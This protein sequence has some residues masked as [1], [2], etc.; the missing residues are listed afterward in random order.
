MVVPER[1][2]R[3][4]LEAVIGVGSF[5]TVHRA[6]DDW[7]E[8]TVA[9]KV[10]AENHSLNPE[11]RERFIAEGRSLRRIT[12]PHVVTV[13]DIG[14]SQHQQPYLVLELADRGTLADRVAQ[15]RR[16]GWTATPADV[17]VLARE[18]AAAV[19]AVHEAHLV[20]R[21]LSPGNLLLT[22]APGAGLVGTGASDPAD[23][24]QP[25]EVR[26]QARVVGPD[27]RLIVADLGM[28]K[29]LALNSGLTVAAGTSGFRP[30]EQSGGAGIVDTRADLW[31]LSAVL[32]WLC[33]GADL[34]EELTRVL[35][36][37]QADDPADRH[38]DVAGWLADIE[39]ALRPPEPDNDPH[40]DPAAGTDDTDGSGSATPQETS[41]A[42]GR[43]LLRLVVVTVLAALAFGALGA[44][45]GHR[46]RDGPPSQSA[47][48]TVAIEGP[49][50]VAAGEEVTFSATTT[51]LDS[52]VWTLPSGQHIIDEETITMTAQTAGWAELVLRG[53]DAEGTDLEVTHRLTVTD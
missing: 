23:P 26:S 37:G 24:G 3:Y 39:T 22:T 30:P 27:E 19:E 1:L 50:R 28:C 29:D 46:W 40:P 18:A 10:L 4:R 45:L 21:D 43:P 35:R 12:S 9:V 53:R 34:P 6:A 51:G 49:D 48:A 7:L 25:E 36:R 13:H 31:A 17:L 33:E 44:Y 2:G 41:A 14:E 11:V 38:P 42:T 16:D 20:H 47:S 8:D 15:L 5:A 32:A 52:W